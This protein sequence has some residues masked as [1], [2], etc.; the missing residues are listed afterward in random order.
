MGNVT[1]GVLKAVIALSL[2]GSLVV[3]VMILPTVWNDLD[4]PGVRDGRVSRSSPSGAWRCS[5]CRCSR[6]ASGAS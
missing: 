3:Q 2:A 1:I 4:D 5:P 6:C